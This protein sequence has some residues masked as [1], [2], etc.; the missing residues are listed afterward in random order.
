MRFIFGLAFLLGLSACSGPYSSPTV[1]AKVDSESVRVRVET[2]RS[3]NIPEM[4][5][6]NGELFA[7]EQATLSAK[8][9]G[10]ITKLNVDLGSQVQKNDVIAELETADYDFRLKQ[11]EAM[12]EQTRARL[13]L[14]SGSP[15]RVNPPDTAIVRQAAAGLREATL[16]HANS[17]RLFD[18]GVISKVDFERAGVALQ[19]AQARHQAAVEEVYN[20]LAQLTER[21]A[22]VEL[23]RQQLADTVIRAPFAGAITRRTTA[24]GEYLPVNAGIAVLVRQNPMRIRLSVPERLA[25]RV[26]IGQTVEVRIET[27]GRTRSGQVVRLSPSIEAQNRSLLVEGE[28]PNEDGALR[29]GSFI[30]GM[31]TVDR[32]A[33]G[34]AVPSSCVL[35]FA[36]VDRVFVVESGKL[37]ERVIKPGRALDSSKVQ[38]LEGLKPGDALVLDPGDKLSPGLKVQAS[39]S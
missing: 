21:R 18:Q 34:I 39:G 32:N 28:L 33:R 31:I 26:R 38:V 6:V 16:L 2:I 25:S 4:I 1:A 12:V 5:Q 15:D 22:Q 7:E 36:G 8:V 17:T 29:S 13:G 24:I 10:R 27:A 3:V 35:S 20:L 23:A 14:A 30:E 11:A 9:P 37:A 19:A